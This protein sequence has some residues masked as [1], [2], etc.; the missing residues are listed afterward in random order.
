MSYINPYN[1]CFSPQLGFPYLENPNLENPHLGF[2][3]LVFPNVEN[4]QSSFP[5]VAIPSL[6][7]TVLVN[8]SKCAIILFVC[9]N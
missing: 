2:P 7:N 8:K 6:K 9:A 4:P 5:I 3:Y 1:T